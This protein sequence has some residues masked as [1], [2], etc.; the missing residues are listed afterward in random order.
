MNIYFVK[1]LIYLNYWKYKP[2]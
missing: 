1:I 2:V